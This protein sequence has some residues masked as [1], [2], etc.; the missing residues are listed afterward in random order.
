MSLMV[1]TCK[2]DARL[3][4]ELS[5]TFL[6]RF[7]KLLHGSPL[8][9]EDIA[10][11][12]DRWSVCDDH[13]G[14]VFLL[15]LAKLFRANT[16]TA[17][18]DH[19][20]VQRLNDTL[21]VARRHPD[22][23]IALEAEM[24][25]RVN[26]NASCCVTGIAVAPPALD[27]VAI[28]HLRSWCSAANILHTQLP[29][30]PQVA[31]HYYRGLRDRPVRRLDVRAIMHLARDAGEV[32][33]GYFGMRAIERLLSGQANWHWTTTIMRAR[34]MRALRRTVMENLG[35]GDRTLRY[36]ALRCALVGADQLPQPATYD[37]VQR[38][39]SDSDAL[40]TFAALWVLHYWYRSGAVRQPERAQC[41]A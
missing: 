26:P 18:V 15:R 7:E 19:G 34:F 20:L 29:V 10:I 21:T 25:Y 4:H 31:K 14:R 40:L 28:T 39:A 1:S 13:D 35:V 3:I 37:A 6:I 32:N 16:L 17:S 23:H 2:L 41:C 9:N 5:H 33:A 11:F 36:G 38:I 12:L 27:N 8:L 22:R 24:L 30:S